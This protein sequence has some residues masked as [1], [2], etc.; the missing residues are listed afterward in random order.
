MRLSSG[1]M[2]PHE[3]MREVLRNTS[4][5]RIAADMGL[6]LS[7]VYKWAEPPAKP[8][9]AG[10]SPLE[11]VNQLVQ[12]TGDTRIA[13]WV[14]ERSG[15]F[16]IRNPKTDGTTGELIPATNDIVQEFADMLRTIAQSSAD[17]VIT[18]DEAKKI[19]ARWEQLKSVTEGFVQA[20][21]QGSFRPAGTGAA[22]A[23]LK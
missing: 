13:S 3:V 2:E 17:S 9:Q 22:P 20:A 19:R 6:S 15:G 12:I 10:N 1:A 18:A 14:C 5:K 4:A 11:R 16:Y 8:G 7:L 21:E 23:T